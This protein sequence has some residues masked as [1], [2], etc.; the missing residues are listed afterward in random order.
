LKQKTRSSDA[1]SKTCAYYG[2][3]GKTG[4]VFLVPKLLLGNADFPLSPARGHNHI[5]IINGSGEN[6]FYPE[7]YFKIIE[8]PDNIKKAIIAVA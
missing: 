7:D 4:W 3:L 5:R 1:G 6:Y 8:L 2:S